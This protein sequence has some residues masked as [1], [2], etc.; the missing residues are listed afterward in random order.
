[1]HLR[2]VCTAVTSSLIKGFSRD[3]VTR[4]QSIPYVERLSARCP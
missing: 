1:M 2:T 3:G 4:W